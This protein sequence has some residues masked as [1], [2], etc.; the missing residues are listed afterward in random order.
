MPYY[1]ASGGSSIQ[2]TAM[3]WYV[4]QISWYSGTIDTGIRRRRV[5]NRGQ[6][7]GLRNAADLFSILGLPRHQ[8]AQKRSNIAAIRRC[9]SADSCPR[10]SKIYVHPHW[11]YADSSCLTMKTFLWSRVGSN[12]PYYAHG[13]IYE[14][15]NLQSGSVQEKNVLDEDNSVRILAKRRVNT[16]SCR[17]TTPCLYR[18]IAWKNHFWMQWFLDIVHW[19]RRGQQVVTVSCGDVPRVPGH[20]EAGIINSSM[21]WWVIAQSSYDI[22]S[23]PCLPQNNVVGIGAYLP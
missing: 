17:Q 14:F 15:A 4:N 13:M 5:L 16:W 6:N 11:A 8:G 23:R 10:W 12:N 7:D 21:C 22:L 20:D 9:W 18:H 19:Y 1:T 3:L 2:E